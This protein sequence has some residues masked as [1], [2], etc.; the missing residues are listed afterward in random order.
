[1]IL[2]VIFTTQA[3]ASLLCGLLQLCYLH[4]RSTK[5]FMDLWKNIS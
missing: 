4:L 5:C 3:L 2:P 1:V